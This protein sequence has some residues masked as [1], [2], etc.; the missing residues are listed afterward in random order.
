M[1]MKMKRG[2]LSSSIIAIL[3]IAVLAGCGNGGSGEGNGT[4]S[5]GN[6]NGEAGAVAFPWDQLHKKIQIG[7]SAGEL[8]DVARLDI[9]W[10]PEFQDAGLLVPLD[11]QFADFDEVVGQFLEGPVSTA[12]VGDHYYALPLNTNTKVLF[13]NKDL[14][15][16]AGLTEAPA[17]TDQFFSA[18]GKLKAA[19]PDGW[20]YG[21]PALQGWNILPWLWSNGADVLSP[22]YDSATGYLNAPETANILKRLREAYKQGELADLNKGMCRLPKDMRTAPMR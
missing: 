19:N 6:E 22:Q 18:L 17:T 16:K 10:V 13:W 5:G 4:A 12:K 2:R 9:I 14:F 7:G 1:N 20:G 15:A 11:E 3:L 21:E 8:P